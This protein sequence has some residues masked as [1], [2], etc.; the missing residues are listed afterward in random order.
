[1]KTRLYLLHFIK[2]G[3]CSAQNGQFP[4]RDQPAELGTGA[5]FILFDGFFIGQTQGREVKVLDLVLRQLF[6][7]ERRHPAKEEIVD[8]MAVDEVVVILHHADLAKDIDVR[9]EL[10]LQLAPDGCL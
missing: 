9:A 4:V 6:V 1:M 7:A 10:F 8:I 2:K 5:F 3:F